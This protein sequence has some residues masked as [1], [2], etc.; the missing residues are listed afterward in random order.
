[1]KTGLFTT[2][3]ALVCLAVPAALAA[4][5]VRIVKAIEFR[6]LKL[7]SKYDVVMGARYR[8]TESGIVIDLDSL[9][10]AIKK[11]G[12]IE[13][14]RIEEKG[15]SLVVAVAERVPEL[16]VAAGGDGGSVLY[17]VDAAHR[18]ISRN[19][20]HTDRVPVIYLSGSFAPQGDAAYRAGTL[21]S[22]LGR[23]KKKVPSVYRELSEI[24]AAGNSIRVVLRGRKTG[25]TM[26]PDE[27]GFIRLKY[28]VGYCD[29]VGQ[30]PDEINL[31]GNAVIVR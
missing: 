24:H 21:F 25:F 15:G 18:V 9:E 23:V 1:M 14:Y 28:I 13:S 19:D 12:F 16:I 2:A 31:S 11:N 22:L 30:Y 7:L 20:V 6:G 29:S 8:A 3:L 5:D 26:R 27:A 17:E 10:Q 4:E